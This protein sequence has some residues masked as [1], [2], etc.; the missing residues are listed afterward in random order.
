MRYSQNIMGAGDAFA[1]TL[2]G[3]MEMRMRAA[4]AAIEEGIDMK[5]VGAW[6]AKHEEKFR[7]EIFVRDKHKMFVVSDKA[8]SLA[9]DEAAMTKALPEMLGIFEKLSNMPGGMFFFPFVR[10]PLNI[11]KSKS[12]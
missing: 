9:G 7:N 8:A 1:R 10:T 11:L 5:N 4:R 3:R 12:K 6:A 2:I